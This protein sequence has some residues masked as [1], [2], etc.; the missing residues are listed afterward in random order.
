MSDTNLNHVFGLPEDSVTKVVPG[1][2]Y[3]GY[4]NVWVGKNQFVRLIA[5]DYTTIKFIQIDM[6][7]STA[8][9]TVV[10]ED[11]DN[12]PL[13]T[14]VTDKVIEDPVDPENDT[15]LAPNQ[16]VVFKSNFKKQVLSISAFWQPNGIPLIRLNITKV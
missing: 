7:D 6:P 8:F 5:T 4:M 3:D 9:G 11:G 1:D 12:I 10:S 15:L 16:A 13:I 14:D 2:G